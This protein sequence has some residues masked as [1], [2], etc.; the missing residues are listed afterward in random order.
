MELK[1]SVEGEYI[2]QTYMWPTWF[3]NPYNS[4]PITRAGNYVV[5]IQP[6]NIAILDISDSR[7]IEN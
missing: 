2:W 1:A 3:W 4:A 5:M 6:R 7:S